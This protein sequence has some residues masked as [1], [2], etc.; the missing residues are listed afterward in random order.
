MPIRS[1]RSRD[2]TGMLSG[3]DWG[4]AADRLILNEGPFTA[5]GLSK[6]AGL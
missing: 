4:V 6:A 1:D 5:F 2:I 3:Y